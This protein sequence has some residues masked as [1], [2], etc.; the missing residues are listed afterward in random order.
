MEIAITTL[1]AD[2]IPFVHDVFTQNID[3][4]HGGEVI[5]EKDWYDGLLGE[6]ADP[7][8]VNFIILS[9]RRP[10]AWLKIN[11]LNGDTACISMLVVDRN[12]QRQGVG[13]FAVRYAEGYARE[14]GKTAVRIQTTRDNTAAANCYLR[15]GY[16]I[17]REMKYAVGDGVLRDGY[18]FRKEL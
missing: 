5:S 18:E 8:E 10:A 3:I 13:S 16:Q 15:L 4:L 2:H 17:A 7:Y 11:G 9:D 12:F 6:C 14:C 1:T